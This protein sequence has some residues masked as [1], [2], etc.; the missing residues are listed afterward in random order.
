LDAAQRG[1]VIGR[2]KPDHDDF[3]HHERG[4]GPAVEVLDQLAQD[5]RVAA[6][7][8]LLKGDSTGRKKLFRGD[9]GWSAGLSVKAHAGHASL[10]SVHPPAYSYQFIFAG[11][12]AHRRGG[13]PAGEGG[14]AQNR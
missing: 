8:L 14:G 2:V 7:V 12:I 5:L 4:R 10:P 9:T 6:D 11:A 13:R 3:A 1:L